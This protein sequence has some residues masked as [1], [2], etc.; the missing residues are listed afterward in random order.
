M[1]KQRDFVKM[2][3]LT[4]VTF[5][6]YGIYFW[7]CYT[8][9][10]NKAGAGDG[11]ESPNYII[12]ILLGIVTCGIYLFWWYY[13]QGNRLQAIGA[14]HGLNIQE[15]GTTVLMWMIFGSLLCGIG[16]YVA[17]YIMIKNMNAVAVQYNAGE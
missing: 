15:N 8:E 3:I 4:I 7:Y 17:M 9:D 12:V 2:L 1:I 13:K 5:G 16:S 10:L 14:K 11:Q 6:I